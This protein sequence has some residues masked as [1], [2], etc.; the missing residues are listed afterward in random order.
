MGKESMNL[1]AW[2]YNLFIYLSWCIY[3][4]IYI[5]ALFPT[6]NSRLVGEKNMEK[7]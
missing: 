3:V 1:T 4:Y 7:I 6:F 5:C 2:L